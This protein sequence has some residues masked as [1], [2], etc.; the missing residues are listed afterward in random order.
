[1]RKVNTRQE[2]LLAVDTYLPRNCTGVEIGTLYGDFASE[3]RRLINPAQLILIDPYKKN[4]KNYGIYL[5]CSPTAYSTEDDYQNLVRRFEP[6]LISGKVKIIRDFSYSAVVDFPDNSIDFCYIDGSHLKEDVKRDLND[7]L[8]KV[9][10][11]GLILGHDYIVAPDFGVI[12]AVNEFCEE[13]RFEMII[14]NENGGDWA[15]KM[16]NI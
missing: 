12:E 8:P 10:E 2:F 1:M 15:L 5:N 7:W 4:D 16:G 9:K 14:F 11:G 13:H 3:I 6:E